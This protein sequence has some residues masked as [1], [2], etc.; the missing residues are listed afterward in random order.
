MYCG[1]RNRG[2]RLSHVQWKPRLTIVRTEG[3]AATQA[4]A[5]YERRPPDLEGPTVLPASM[6]GGGAGT[7]SGPEAAGGVAV[8][9]ASSGVG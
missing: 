6:A 7:T 2:G 9:G 8:V 3:G 1:G 4:A 5:K